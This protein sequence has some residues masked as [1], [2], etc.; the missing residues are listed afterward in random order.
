MGFLDKIKKVMKDNL[1]VD[2]DKKKRLQAFKEKYAGKDL[3]EMKL[4]M[5]DLWKVSSEEE[6]DEVRAQYAKALF[7][8]PKSE[9]GF[10]IAADRL[11]PDSYFGKFDIGKWVREYGVAYHYNEKGKIVSINRKLVFAGNYLN[12]DRKVGMGMLCLVVDAVFRSEEVGNLSDEDI[13][14]EHHQIY[15]PWLGEPSA[16]PND[17]DFLQTKVNAALILCS[18]E[19]CEQYGAFKRKN[20]VATSEYATVED[21]TKAKTKTQLDNLLDTLQTRWE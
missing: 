1:G 13:M 4:L 18:P 17:R 20:G 14:N 21:L 10:G 7:A 9:G 15:N 2:V 8:A 5:E 6:A 3:E 11:T 12:A 16:D 19:A